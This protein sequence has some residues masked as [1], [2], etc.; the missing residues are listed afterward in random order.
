MEER[1]NK[2]L[3]QKNKLEEQIKKAQGKLKLINQELTNI[4]LKEKA[5]NADEIINKLKEQGIENIET[6]LNYVNQGKI[7]I[8]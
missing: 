5:K 7:N 3:N 4:E 1:K 8:K 2:L 6:L